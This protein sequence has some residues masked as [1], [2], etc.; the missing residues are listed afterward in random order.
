MKPNKWMV[1]FFNIGRQL[2]HEGNLVSSCIV[3]NSGSFA[4]D[5]EMPAMLG[6]PSR[7]H[8]WRKRALLHR[9]GALDRVSR[10][11]RSSTK[12]KKIN[13]L[14]GGRHKLRLKN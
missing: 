10:C 11:S 13:M 6:T 8:G 2:D 5:Q 9:S 12:N 3:R 1:A 14:L 7:C 4:L